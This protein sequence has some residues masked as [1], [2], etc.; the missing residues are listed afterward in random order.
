MAVMHR[1]L[2]H[3]DGVGG[4]PTGRPDPP[5]A[6]TGRTAGG[7]STVS[8]RAVMQLEFRGRAPPCASASGR[9]SSVQRGEVA[10]RGCPAP[11]M[12][13]ALLQRSRYGEVI[14]SH[15][16]SR[17]AEAPRRGRRRC[18]PCRRCRP[19]GY[20]AC[21]RLGVSQRVQQR[22]DAR[23]SRTG[24]APVVGRGYRRGPPRSS[25]WPSPPLFESAR[26]AAGAAAPHW[27][28]RHDD[29]CQR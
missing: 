25:P 15:L 13:D 16:V 28:Q 12:L 21:P 9:S 5:L 23:Q 2:R 3:V 10:V 7:G 6:R 17:G 14:E 22:A 27:R 1:G 29:R 18:C 24:S 20:R 26:S 4:V 11:L 8:A 19:H